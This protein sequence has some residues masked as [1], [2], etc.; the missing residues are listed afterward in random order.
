MNRQKVT[1]ILG[2]VPGNYHENLKFSTQKLINRKKRYCSQTTI[3]PG[4]L[5]VA[6][7]SIFCTVVALDDN[8]PT[9]GL[10]KPGMCLMD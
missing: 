6:L 7:L 3:N 2:K 9:L 10:E 5:T 4:N 1:K 8:S